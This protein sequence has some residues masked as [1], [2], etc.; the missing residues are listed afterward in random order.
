MLES[1]MLNTL[2]IGNRTLVS[3]ISGSLSGK[4]ISLAAA[5]WHLLAGVEFPKV[6]A[7]TVMSGNFVKH[8]EGALMEVVG[9]ATLEPKMD[10][11]SMPDSA[12]LVDVLLIEADVE[13]ELEYGD[14][15]TVG[16]RLGV[17]HGSICEVIGVSGE[18]RTVFEVVGVGVKERTIVKVINIVEDGFLDVL[19]EI[20][21]TKLRLSAARV[22]HREQARLQL[23]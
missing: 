1:Y 4:N 20:G 2:Q 10:S 21:H 13:G 17:E 11:L 22:E 9:A 7:L 19:L 14:G 16:D 6:V 3:L 23:L 8:V 15:N 18:E 5:R 12:L